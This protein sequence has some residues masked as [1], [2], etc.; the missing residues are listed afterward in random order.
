[1]IGTIWPRRSSGCLRDWI[2]MERLL[3]RSPPLFGRTPLTPVLSVI[4]CTLNQASYLRKALTS[5]YEQTLPRAEYE[6]L[7]VDNG[8]QIPQNRLWNRSATWET[9]TTFTIMS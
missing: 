8:L 3:G 4:V 6:V 5:I 9:C 7:V 1:M 2:G